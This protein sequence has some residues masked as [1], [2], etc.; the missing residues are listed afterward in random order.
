MRTSDHMGECHLHVEYAELL[1]V[2]EWLYFRPTNHL[3]QRVLSIV[4][5]Q[6]FADIRER[7]HHLLVI[8]RF[9]NFIQA[10]TEGASSPFLSCPS[11]RTSIGSSASLTTSWTAAVQDWLEGTQVHR[12][13]RFCKAIRGTTASSFSNQLYL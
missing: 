12:G 9:N 13:V 10:T 3:F 7:F 5:S 1:G 11:R 6:P 2:R 4:L 8:F